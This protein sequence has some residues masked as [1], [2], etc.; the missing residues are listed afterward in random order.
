MRNTTIKVRMSCN[1]LYNVAIDDNI[2][3]FIFHPI[4]FWASHLDQRRIVNFAEKSLN[5]DTSFYEL[6]ALIHHNLCSFIHYQILLVLQN[7]YKR[8]FAPSR[9]DLCKGLKPG[10]HDLKGI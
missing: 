2:Q 1:Y 8:L 6:A 7:F 9:L 4:V 5:T 10:E 3:I